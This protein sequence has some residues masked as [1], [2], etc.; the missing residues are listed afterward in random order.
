MSIDERLRE[1]GA[2]LGEVPVEPPSFDKLVRRRQVLRRSVTVVL[3][4]GILLV[5]VVAV[6]AVSDRPATEFAAEGTTPTVSTGSIEGRAQPTLTI[7]PVVTDPNAT[8][9]PSSTSA[10]VPADALGGVTVVIANANG[11]GGTAA[12]LSRDLEAQLGL[13]MGEPTDASLD[14]GVLEITL[15]YYAAQEP[16]AQVIASAVDHILGGDTTVLPLPAGPPPV[17][18]GDLSGADV[19]VLLGLDKAGKPLAELAPSA[20][21]TPD[22]ATTT[23]LPSESATIAHADITHTDFAEYVA[24]ARLVFGAIEIGDACPEYWST[25]TPADWGHLVVVPATPGVECVVA[26]WT[27]SGFTPDDVPAGSLEY[28]GEGNTALGPIFDDSGALLGHF[29]PPT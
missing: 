20:N 8:V 25:L 21:T 26:G 1:A 13:R 11:I 12:A 19:L 5:G 3:A 17:V 28:V 18:T 7:E 2:R 10:I 4:V 9:A 24:Q 6:R 22:V 16:G 14:V 29:P 15:V 23:T 27:Y